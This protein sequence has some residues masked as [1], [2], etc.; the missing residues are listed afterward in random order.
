MS[1]QR[2]NVYDAYLYKYKKI[3]IAISYTPGLSVDS[4]IDDIAKTFNLTIVNL[5]GPN[6]LKPDSVFNYDKLNADIDKILFNS[7]QKLNSS[8]LGYYGQ[9]IIIHGLNFPTDKLKFHIDLQL[10]LSTSS[11]MFLKSNVDSKGQMIY[12]IDDY[13]KFRD[14]LANNKINK[15]YNIK[16]D[17]S[18]DFNDMIYEKII[19]FLEF[20]V[21]GKDYEL[22][23]SKNANKKLDN[24]K[25]LNPK[26]TDVIE[27]SKKNDLIQQQ[28]DEDIT[29][30]A[31]SISADEADENPIF[32]TKNRHTSRSIMR[33]KLSS[34]TEDIVSNTDTVIP[35]D[36]FLDKEMLNIFESK[37]YSN[38]MNLNNIT[39]SEIDNLLKHI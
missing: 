1:S 4:L 21:Y 30:A 13:N 10:H 37:Q 26:P 28:I 19:D 17:L 31:L 2:Y 15:Y 5:E 14:I 24:S 39:D 12:N 16:S 23:A 29:D 7:Q 9:G 35:T 3:I 38:L 33:K 34:S 27:I 11:S 6:M 22:Y 25:I 8:F 18:S 36:E 32:P 20:K